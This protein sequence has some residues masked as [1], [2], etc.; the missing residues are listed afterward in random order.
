MSSSSSTEPGL[1]PAVATYRERLRPG[2]GLF[3]ALLLLIPAVML[4]VT[5]ISGGAALPIAIGVY[6]VISAAL[7][8][9]SPVLRIENG[10]FAA[11]NAQISVSLLGAARTLDRD[12]LRREIGPG[13]D[14]RSYL[15]IRGYIHTAVQIKVVDPADPTPQW[16][17]TTRRPA[18]LLA[19]LEAAKSPA[20]KPTG[21]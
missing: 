2:A 8:L 9:L 5:P 10:R 11:G 3:V 18:Q 6:V 15:L 13:A 17:V 16:I 12:G 1:S 14:A 19:A 4:M 7:W 21:E 20:A